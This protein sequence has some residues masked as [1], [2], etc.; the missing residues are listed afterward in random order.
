MDEDIKAIIIEALEDYKRWFDDIEKTESDI[1][2][3][4]EIDRALEEMN[5]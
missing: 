3:I 1:E 2:K 4:K 5:K